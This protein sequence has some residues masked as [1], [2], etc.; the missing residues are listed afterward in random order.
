MS[1]YK[2]VCI[3]TRRFARKSCMYKKKRD[4]MIIV[5]EVLITRYKQN[6]VHKNILRSEKENL[7]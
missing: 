6:R 4:Y 5:T 7:P 2:N 1:R 3:F